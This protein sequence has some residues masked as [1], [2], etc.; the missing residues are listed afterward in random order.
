MPEGSNAPLRVCAL[1]AV[2]GCVVFLACGSL[3][4]VGAQGLAPVRMRERLLAMSPARREGLRRTF[5][6]DREHAPARLLVKFR[7]GGEVAARATVSRL[8]GGRSV[9]H[10]KSSDTDVVDFPGLHTELDLLA[11]AAS[12]LEGGL[13]ERIAA[14]SVIH[15][16]AAP[17]DPHY[18]QQWSLNNHRKGYKGYL[19]GFDIDAERAWSV[20]HGSRSVVVAAADTGIDLGHPDLAANLWTNSGETGADAQG[21]DKRTNGVDDDGNGYVDD[22]HGWDWVQDDNHPSDAGGHGTH[23]AGTIGAVGDNNL[24]L[25]GVCWRVSLAT[26]RILEP[27]GTGTLSAAVRALEYAADMGFPIVN[28]SWGVGIDPP[29]LR[30]AIRYGQ[31]RG[32]LF[33]CAAGNSGANLSRFP[34]YPACYASDFYSVINVAASTA[35]GNLLHESNYG[36]RYVQIAAPGW[37]I[38][39]TYPRSKGNG[40]GY[41]ASSGTSMAAPHLSGGAALIKAAA[42][43]LTAAEIKERLLRLAVTVPAFAGRVAGNRHL[44]LARCVSRDVKPP[45]AIEAPRLLD[46]GS[47]FARLE[48]HA[49]PDRTTLG[50]AVGYQVRFSPVPFGD[51]SVWQHAVP[52]TA[53]FETSLK[54][55]KVKVRVAGMP[56][57]ST[58]YLAIRGEDAVVN[59]GPPGPTLEVRT[60]PEVTLFRDDFES[61][62]PLHCTGE[63]HVGADPDRTGQQG[64]VLTENATGR[65]RPGEDS[66]A[67]L[68]LLSVGRSA[69]DGYR[70]D[71]L[72]SG[73]FWGQ[74][75]GEGDSYGAVDGRTPAR[76]WHP[77]ALFDWSARRSS[78]TP[79]SCPLDALIDGTGVLHL[80]F[81]SHPGAHAENGNWWIDQLVVHG[82]FVPLLSGLPHPESDAARLH[83]TVG[84]L[85]VTAYRFAL[86]RPH[87]E[88]VDATFSDWRN[89]DHKITAHTGAP[90]LKRLCVQARS[91]K[92]AVSSYET[93]SWTQR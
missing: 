45:E 9:A 28:N 79:A 90:G 40:T 75:A 68:P 31:E 62:T 54:V 7:S 25:T 52:L 55:R 89:T 10:L 66:Y 85:G 13:A 46:V 91:A 71:F 12:L 47:T 38:P 6:L 27:D 42:P 64:Q 44:S 81:R 88:P 11:A 18:D 84:G 86:L 92:G 35:E 63:W 60:P 20:S 58:G 78:W 4:P 80:R 57:N 76:P 17:N 34:E 3:P 21:H 74:G 15:A 37:H 29:E 82:P 51:E 67:T 36:A 2:L 8:L 26:L 14:D 72:E 32:V 16:D 33:A 50:F 56:P 69:T 30:E 39:S 59:L 49:A 5:R 61:D 83:V 23:V 73:V 93:Y 70:L 41:H 87:E 65:R 48:F 53:T 22:V 43:S 1:L 77:I 24:G 19:F